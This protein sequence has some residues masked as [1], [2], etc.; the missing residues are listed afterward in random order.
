M[1]YIIEAVY[2]GL[3]GTENDYVQVSSMDST[4]TIFK[5]FLKWEVSIK[6]ARNF[7]V[8]IL[9]ETITGVD[10]WYKMCQRGSTP[11]M[12][13]V[14]NICKDLNKYKDFIDHLVGQDMDV[15]EMLNHN[16]ELKLG[17]I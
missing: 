13:E 5:V 15:R 2:K 8:P 14:N 17:G 6:H 1:S 3:C 9:E 7:F 4:G 11:L 16:K 10:A 12:T